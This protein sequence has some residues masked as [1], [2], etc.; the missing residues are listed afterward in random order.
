MFIAP[1]LPTG[2]RSIS[3]AASERW[4]TWYSA[5][6]SSIADSAAAERCFSNSLGLDADAMA[7]LDEEIGPHPDTYP[8]RALGDEGAFTRW[9]ELPMD[10]LIDEVIAMRGGSRA[11]ATMTFVADRRLEVLAHGLECHPTVLDEARERLGLLPPGE[12]KKA[13]A[14]LVSY[15]VGIAFGRWDVRIGQDPSLAPAQPELF[16]PV[17]PCPPGMLL[18][19]DGFPSVDAPLN[20]PLEVPSSGLLVDEPGHRWDLETAVIGA[21][22]AL[23]S[24]REVNLDEMLHILG[25]GSVRDHL[26]RQFF[27]DHLSR[28]SKSRRKAPIYW[29]LTVPSR[30]WGLWIYAPTLSRETLY[31][32][33]SEAARR[34]RLAVEA[35]T[36]L[37][38]EQQEGGRGSQTGRSPR[39]LIPR[40]NWPKSCA[41]FGPSPNGLRALDGSPISTTASFSVLPRSPI[42]SR[43]G[44]RPRRPE[45]SFA[46]AATVGPPS[47]DGRSSCDD[48][49]ARPLG[50]RAG[51][52]GEPARRRSLA[53]HG[54]RVRGGRRPAVPA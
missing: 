3:E 45:T 36:R 38:R 27:K 34:E 40:R 43:R 6:I 8:R 44:Q 11:V 39:N 37:Q 47:L 1:P 14:D 28:Y 33:A 7:Y 35:I 52:E 42:S 30:S 18:G 20:Y 22:H 49:V 26:R 50:S 17:P 24:D 16:D 25:R 41:G 23:L 54:P 48:R 12:P 2:G 15:L 29:P 51:E 46:R 13:A 32:I 53:G 9:F 31:V 19:P 10:Q 21:A 5:A 4:R